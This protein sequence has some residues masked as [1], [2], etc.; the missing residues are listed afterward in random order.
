MFP[1]AQGLFGLA[2][3][4]ITAISL[5]YSWAEPSLVFDTHPRV[6]RSSRK[7]RQ[8]TSASERETLTPSTDLRPCSSTPIA[9]STAAL[10]TEPPCRTFS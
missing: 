5:A 7:S 4:G 1:V 3:L 2:T 6:R 8:C 9:I 10:T